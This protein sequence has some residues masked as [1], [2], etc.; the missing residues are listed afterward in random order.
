M[1]QETSS[2]LQADIH[3]QH[4]VYSGQVATRGQ[5]LADFL[6]DP[7]TEI[8]EMRSVRISQVAS[9]AHSMEC[10]HV[11]LRKDSI[12]LAI[13]QGKYE[14]PQRRAYSYVEKE[15]FPAHVTLPGRCLAGTMHLPPRTDDWAL[16]VDKTTMASFIPITDVTVSLAAAAEPISAKVVIFRRQ[17]MESLFLAG[18]RLAAPT[19]HDQAVRHGDQDSTDLS[20][21]LTELQAASQPAQQPGTPTPARPSLGFTRTR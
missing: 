10:E 7:M 19:L 1:L 15:R 13:P 11:L 21:L 5:R 8:V 6:N 17:F 20:R 12:L 14:A 4:A 16:M 18:R 2:H 9:S 3:T